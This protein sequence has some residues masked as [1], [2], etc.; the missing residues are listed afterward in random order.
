MQLQGRLVSA[1]C[2][3][4]RSAF[5]TDVDHDMSRMERLWGIERLL[6]AQRAVPLATLI[7]E[8]GV[9]RATIVRDLTY[10]KIGYRLPFYGTAN[11]AVTG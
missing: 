3:G 7:E 5:R 8:T 1:D 2:G 10:L 9:S 4:W 11:S 6:R